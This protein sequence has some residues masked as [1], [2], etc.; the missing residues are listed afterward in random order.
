MQDC[1]EFSQTVHQIEQHMDQE[2]D[3]F[4]SICK[5]VI[6]INQAHT[7]LHKGMS[8]NNATDAALAL[9]PKW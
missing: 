2:Y 6:G 3:E 5:V 8:K 4:L 1:Q 7:K 9:T